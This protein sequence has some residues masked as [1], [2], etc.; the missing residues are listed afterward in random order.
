MLLSAAFGAIDFSNVATPRVA[1]SYTGH[2]HQ[3]LHIQTMGPTSTLVYLEKSP[4][5]TVVY[6]IECNMAVHILFE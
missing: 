4:I 2:T 5:T 6:Y 1:T 3:L